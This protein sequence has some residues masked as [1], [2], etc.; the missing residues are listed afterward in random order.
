MH[1]KEKNTVS[2]QPNKIYTPIFFNTNS[3][4]RAFHIASPL[5]TFHLERNIFQE[6]NLNSSLLS[7][8]LVSLFPQQLIAQKVIFLFTAYCHQPWLFYHFFLSPYFSTSIIQL[9]QQQSQVLHALQVLFS[10]RMPF[11]FC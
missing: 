1:T 5:L 11:L 3:H 7:L 4:C 9:L 10:V 2:F 8:D 6:T